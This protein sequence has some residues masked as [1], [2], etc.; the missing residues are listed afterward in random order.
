M[1]VKDALGI[2]Q[3]R[4]T[5]RDVGVEIE[6]EGR[7]LPIPERYWRVDR[8]GSLRGE[9]ALEYVLARPSS[10]DDVEKALAHLREA[11]NHA[12]SRIDETVRAGVHIHINCQQLTLK[13]LYN[14]FVLYLALENVLIKYCGE[15]RE[16]NLFCLRCQDAEFLLYELVAAAKDRGFMRHFHSDDLRYASMNV[17]A[18]GDYGSLEFRAMR[19]TKD[20]D[21]ILDWAKILLNLRQVAVKFDNPVQIIQEVSRIGCMAFLDK[22]LGPHAKFFKGVPEVD[23]LLYEGVQLAQCVAYCVKW[24]TWEKPVMIGGLAFPNDGK[25]YEEPIG[26]A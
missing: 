23:N 5:N 1:L 12:N 19:S 14:F 6:I 22:C 26:D 18:L 4:H 20:F 25:F 13:E 8:D 7:R 2:A 15:Y 16:G 17:K 9:E 24:E 11:F 3:R 10:I 21:A